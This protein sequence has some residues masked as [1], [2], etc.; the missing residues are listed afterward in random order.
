M[1]VYH[2]ED[3][4]LRQEEN[5]ADYQRRIIEWFDH[6]LKGHEAAPWIDQE[7]P[8]LEQKETGGG[9]R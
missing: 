7:I 2:G 6:Y 5:Q 4:G 1:L 3:H 9:G 8:W